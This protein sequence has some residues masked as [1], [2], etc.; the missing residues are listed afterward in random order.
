[1]ANYYSNYNLESEVRAEF[2]SA[3][4]RAFRRKWLKFGQA[5]NLADFNKAQHSNN[6]VDMGI[7]EIDV[8]QIKGSVS[9][10]RNFDDEFNPRNTVSQN[11]WSRLY[12]GYLQGD[13]IP[14][15]DVYKIEDTYYVEDGHHRVSVSRS[16]GRP[17]I[18]AHIIDFDTPS[19]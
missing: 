12:I 13:P 15:I 8:S 17:Y 18:D 14:P 6:R 16:I 4:N 1:M 10:N 7:H 19:K 9:N 3:K 11:R 5:Q 2:A